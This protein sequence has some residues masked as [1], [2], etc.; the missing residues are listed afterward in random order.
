MK[1]SFGLIGYVKNKQGIPIPANRVRAGQRI[2]IT[3][4][5]GGEVFFIRKASYDAESKYLKMEPEL[6]PDDITE[7]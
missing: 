5:N 6:P 4:Y 1:T 2:K 7:K 3:D